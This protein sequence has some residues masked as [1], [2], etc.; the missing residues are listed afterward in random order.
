MNNDHSYFCNRE[1]EHFPCHKT[2]DEENFNC[3]FCFCPLYSLGENCGGNFVIMENGVKDCSSCLLPHKKENYQ[4]IADRL[5]KSD[6]KNLK[7][8]FP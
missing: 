4:L 3:L 6:G 8:R 1:C 2:N 5:V 7:F